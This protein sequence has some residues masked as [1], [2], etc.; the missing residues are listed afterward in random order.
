[1]TGISGSHSRLSRGVRPRLEGKQR[2]PL[3][4]RVATG[5]SWS[6]Q[7]PKGSR[8]SCEVW[9]EDSGFLSRPCRKRRPSSRD[10]GGVSWVFSICGA[11]VV[12][13]TMYDRELREP[14]VWRQG[15]QI[16]IREARGSASLL[17]SHGKG[18]G[19]EDALRKDSR[20]LSPVVVGNSGFPRLVPVTSGS[21]SGCL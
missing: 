21:F 1:M 4:S 17:S 2:T 12:F 7:W 16:S 8:S 15:N 9:I 6:Q 11:I 19:P 20:G 14:L 10:D 3:S 13:L 5:I 18:I